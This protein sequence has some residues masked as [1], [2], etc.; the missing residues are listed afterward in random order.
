MAS[1]FDRALR[2][3]HGNHNDLIQIMGGGPWTIVGNRFGQRQGGAAQIFVSPGI[4]NRS[5]AIH[6]VSI[7]SNLFTGK[8]G[9]ALQVAGGQKSGIGPPINVRIVNNTIL[10][11]TQSALRLSDTFGALEPAKRPLVANNIFAVSN[12]GFCR[13]AR[14]FKNLVEKGRPCEGDRQGS[15]KLG[16]DEGPTRQSL[17]VING[18]DRRFAP[19]TDFFGKGRVGA[20]DLGAIEFRP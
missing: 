3:A 11:G 10:S 17:L 8:M 5:N 19:P 18:G 12:G 4:R 15:A 7:L 14:V 6:D 2:G 9:F 16:A 20:P 1:S 13:Q